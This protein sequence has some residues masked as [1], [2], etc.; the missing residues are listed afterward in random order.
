VLQ[1]QIVGNA[2]GPKEIRPMSGRS[3]KRG[4][5][6]DPWIA[7]SVTIINDSSCQFDVNPIETLRTGRINRSHAVDQ[8][9]CLPKNRP[10]IQKGV[11]LN[12]GG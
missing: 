9:I 11:E 8:D 2:F 12:V 3:T 4:N 6:H 7:D 5:L 10:V 1:Q